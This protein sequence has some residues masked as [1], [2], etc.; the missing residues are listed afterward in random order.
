MCH[1][2]LYAVPCGSINKV[3]FFFLQLAFFFVFQ[4]CTLKNKDK[5]KGGK[6]PDM[7]HLM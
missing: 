4:T 7:R 2:E 1:K 5:H 3:F 6:I